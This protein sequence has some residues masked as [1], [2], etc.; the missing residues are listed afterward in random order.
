M[1]AI[2]GSQPPSLAV[3]HRRSGPR[4][5]LLLPGGIGRTSLAVGAPTPHVIR[6]DGYR[7]WDDTGRELIDTSNNF[8]VSIHGHAHPEISAAAER[9][10]RGGASFGLPNLYEWEHA[11]LILAR[12]PALDQVRYTNSGTEAVMTAIRVARASTGRDGV[13]VVQDGYHGSSDVALCASSG[14]YRR[15]VPDGVAEDVTVVPLNDATRLRE[16]I[17]RDPG[18]HA[19]VL[20]DLLPNRAGLVS[21]S[22]E[23]VALARELTTRHG[24]VLIVD[25]VISLRLGPHGLS[26]EYSVTP[27]LVTVGKIVGGGFP[28]GAVI[29]REEVMRELSVD[30]PTTY[31]DHGG[32]FSGNPVS[33]AAGTVS[34]RLLTEEAIAR[35]NELGDTARTAVQ[36]RVADAGWEVRGRGSL[37]RPIPQGA[38]RINDDLRCRLWW[39]AHDR[40]L[41]ITPANMISL[42]TPMTEAVVA[43]IADRLADAVLEVA[44]A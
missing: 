41:L 13:I 33:M 12:F 8:S 21:L 15:G 34:L 36:A 38:V 10:L 23:F 2:V 18:R 6:G 5:H 9:A 4:G 3:A 44:D 16:A 7:I 1:N 26:G 22:D 20:I 27:D 29:G 37:L 11:E 14:R 19:A 39:A 35:L 17:E 43:D 28:V 42:S 31:L 32:T 25:E 24:I 40:G 30:Y